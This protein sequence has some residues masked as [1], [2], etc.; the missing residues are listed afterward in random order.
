MKISLKKQHSIGIKSFEWIINS[1]REAF[2]SDDGGLYLI[3]PNRIWD[4]GANLFFYDGRFY[5]DH[6]CEVEIREQ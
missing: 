3:L 5:V 6:F 4:A 1:G 2:V